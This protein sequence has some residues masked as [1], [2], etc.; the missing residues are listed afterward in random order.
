VNNC[1]NSKNRK[2]FH[3]ASLLVMKSAYTT[4][5]EKSHGV[6]PVM[7]QHLRQNLISMVPSYAI[8]WDQQG[9]VYYELLQLN[10][11]NT[12]NQYR[13]QLM[14]LSRALKDKRPRYKQK[15]DKV[16][17]HHDNTQPHVPQ[18]IKPYLETL[19]W[20][21]LPLPCRTLL[22]L[23]QI[24]I[25]LLFVPFNDTRPIRAEILFV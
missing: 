3:I 20:E 2:V 9:I 18:A 7:H 22:I 21:V 17:F 16:I 19:K 15:H 24:T 25:W 23:P 13:L 1:S 11:I 10:E 8:W 6:N 14:R 12:E 4:T 5:S